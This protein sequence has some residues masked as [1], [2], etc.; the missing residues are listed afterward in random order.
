MLHCCTGWRAGLTECP[1]WARGGSSL[2]PCSPWAHLAQGHFT[3]T[4]VHSIFNIGE[5][6]AKME[7]C[8]FQGVRSD[9]TLLDTHGPQGGLTC[10]VPALMWVAITL[11]F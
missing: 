8:L 1:P 3:V 11:S 10:L 5:I 6:H 2:Y 9:S 4:L 7:L